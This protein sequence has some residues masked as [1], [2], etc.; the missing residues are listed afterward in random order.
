MFIFANFGGESLLFS[1][2]NSLKL[3]P[4][5]AFHTDHIRFFPT[6]SLNTERHP[7]ESRLRSLQIGHSQTQL[8]KNA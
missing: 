5:E 7:N 1:A 3:A 4:S 8:G 2:E 6:A